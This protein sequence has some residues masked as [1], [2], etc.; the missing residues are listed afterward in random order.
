MKF[1]NVFKDKREYF[2]SMP[3]RNTN[4]HSVNLL[5]DDIKFDKQLNLDDEIHFNDDIFK[6]IIVTNFGSNGT[7]TIGEA[8]NVTDLGNLFT[9]NTEITS[10]EGIQYFTKLNN[11]LF[12]AFKGC[13]NLIEIPMMCINN[14]KDGFTA[15]STFEYCT[16]LTS[17]PFI[18]FS[19]AEKLK[20]TFFKCSM[21]SDFN[22]KIG[23][24]VKDLE[25]TWY[26]CAS[27]KSFPL[28]DTS[29]VTNLN[30]T[31]SNVGYEEG[32][33]PLSEFD[34]SSVRWN[35]QFIRKLNISHIPRLKFPNIEQMGYCFIDV[36]AESVE[37][38]E[39]GDKLTYMMGVWQS[40]VNLKHFPEMSFKNVPYMG[41]NWNNCNK[42]VTFASYDFENVKMLGYNWL[43]CKSLE[44]FEHELLVGDNTQFDVFR[45]GTTDEPPYENIDDMP[46]IQYDNHP[47]F[48]GCIALK[49]IK[50]KENTVNHN[51]SFP[52]SPLLSDESIDS[53]VKSLK[54]QD[55][56][57]KV[58]LL[59]VDVKTKLT[60]EQ[61]AMITNKNWTLA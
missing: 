53:I 45:D 48:K 33:F 7:I 56:E 55:E 12:E 29:N 54:P 50:I 34:F 32:K 49:N 57:G 14:N 37:P 52:D 26:G 60:E 35:N 38:F 2:S 40:M 4:I 25:M 28:I 17:I 6:E 46:F 19:D 41:K 30:R 47:A 23:K 51:I 15:H 61:I 10:I 31:W 18:D 36:T 24:N 22:F 9:N 21:L 1:L 11:S 42:M 16:S 59:H 20:R 5:N 58:L 13:S 39:Y 44:T 3:K 43:N 27:L 8:L